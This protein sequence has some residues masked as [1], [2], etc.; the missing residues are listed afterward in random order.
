M[1]SPWCW[2]CRPVKSVIHGS[3]LGSTIHAQLD[4]ES[5]QIRIPI[6]R[7]LWV[8]HNVAIDIIP[9]WKNHAKL[10]KPSSVREAFGVCEG[11]VVF[12]FQGHSS[13]ISAI[14]H[15]NCSLW[16]PFSDNTVH[17]KAKQFCTYTMTYSWWSL[18]FKVTQGGALNPG[19]VRILCQPFHVKPSLSHAEICKCFSA[20]LEIRV[21]W[22]LS[23]CIFIQILKW[24][25]RVVLRYLTWW[26]SS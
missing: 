6:I 21:K 15:K 14:K 19:E 12:Y 16:A 9:H 17:G 22:P 23:K 7:V 10:V 1:Q 3:V 18:S 24:C 11:T 8:R 20:C 26:K 5:L 25:V 4:V 2:L 13:H